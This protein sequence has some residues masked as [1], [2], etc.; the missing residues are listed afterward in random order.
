MLIINN[1]QKLHRKLY[2]YLLNDIYIMIVL[3]YSSFRN[4]KLQ[5]VHVRTMPQNYFLSTKLCS[6]KYTFGD[7]IK[8]VFLILMILYINQVLTMNY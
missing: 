5:K 1:V 8:F 7:L 6:L 3:N 2:Y 4:V